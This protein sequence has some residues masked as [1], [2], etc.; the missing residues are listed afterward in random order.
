[1]EVEPPD[2]AFLGSFMPPEVGMQMDPPFGS[3]NKIASVFGLVLTRPE[4]SVGLPFNSVCFSP[5]N[6]RVR[7]VSPVPGLPP[8]Y[9]RFSSHNLSGS[10]LPLN[11]RRKKLLYDL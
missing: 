9:F 1:M 7:E 8:A 6:E 3:A 10:W 2:P 11:Q 5:W 4:S